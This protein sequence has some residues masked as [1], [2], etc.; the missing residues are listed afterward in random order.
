MARAQDQSPAV[1]SCNPQMEI[2][3]PSRGHHHYHHRCQ[4]YL[5][6]RQSHCQTP[7]NYPVGRHQT[8]QQYH[9]YHH[10]YRY[11]YLIHRGR[12]QATRTNHWEIYHHCHLLHL[13]H[14]RWS[15]M[16]LTGRYL[17]HLQHHLHHHHHQRYYQHHQNPCLKI[18]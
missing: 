2:Y 7:P 15:P 1:P 18:R 3:P 4:H 8:D 16:N 14:Y 17:D 5:L 10:Q 12:Y 9:H 11:C 6:H 13:S